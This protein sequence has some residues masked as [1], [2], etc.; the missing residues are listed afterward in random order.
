[1]R[2][3]R[4]IA[5][6]A[7]IT[8]SV[9]LTLA[10]AVPASAAPGSW[11]AYGNTNPITGSSSKWVCAGSKAIAE[12]MMAQVCAIRSRSGRGDLVQGAVIVRNNRSSV[13]S[14]S[15]RVVMWTS[16]GKYDEWICSSSGVAAHSWSVCFGSSFGYLPKVYATGDAKNKPLGYTDDI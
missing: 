11:V 12:N 15:A 4:T 13:A 9:C 3:T 10:S 2:A 1:M 6:L 7:A 5:G 16:I 8:A 14:A